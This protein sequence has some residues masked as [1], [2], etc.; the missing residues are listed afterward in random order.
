AAPG[1]GDSH[2]PP[3]PRVS[4]MRRTAR[5]FLGLLA[6]LACPPALAP[7]ADADPAAVR[8]AVSFYASFDDQVAG[9][10]GG[11]GLAL[12][13][14]TNHPTEKGQFVFEKGFDPKVFR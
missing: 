12:S 5:T 1:G 8:K 13:T 11:G 3:Y 4:P 7:A 2:V 6:V 10:L 14:R 9:D